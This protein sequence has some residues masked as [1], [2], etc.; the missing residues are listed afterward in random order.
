VVA[1]L[2]IGIKHGNRL[3]IGDEEIRL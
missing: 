3:L 2:A 1:I